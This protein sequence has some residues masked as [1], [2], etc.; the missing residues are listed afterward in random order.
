MTHSSLKYLMTKKPLPLFET[1]K[2]SSYK[3][4]KDNEYLVTGS[5]DTVKEQLLD[6]VKRLRVGNL[7]VLLHFGSMSH[8]RAIE[9]IDRFAQG[10]LPALQGVWDEEGWENHWWPQNARRVEKAAA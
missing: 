2:S 4:F 7:M 8:E 3:D 10:V 9:N 5:V 1:L 6:I